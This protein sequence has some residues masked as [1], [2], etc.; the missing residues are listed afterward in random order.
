[1]DLILWRH[2]EAVEAPHGGDDM[3][4]KLTNRGEKQAARMAAW[5]DRQLPESTRI[6]TSPARRTEQTAMALGRKYKCHPGL[7]PDGTVDDLLALAQWPKP[8]GCV[9]VV[10]HQPLLGQTIA[11]LLGL[12][13]LDC[14]VKKGAVWWLRRRDPDG[15]ASTVVVTVQTP[16][17]V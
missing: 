8:K 4:R 2:A 3:A 1:M 6:W 14:A 5:L 11:H 16:E 17:M 9:L 12:N 7:A 13:A 10:G 15:A